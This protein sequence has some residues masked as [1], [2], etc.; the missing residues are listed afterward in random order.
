MINANA[1]FFADNQVTLHNR[2]GFVDAPEVEDRRCLVRLW[3]AGEPRNRTASLSAP[4]AGSK[5]QR[6]TD[7]KA[8]KHFQQ[9]CRGSR[10]AG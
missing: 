8:Q 2:R 4:P 3:L 5:V 1:L 10:L 6:A 7:I 9:R